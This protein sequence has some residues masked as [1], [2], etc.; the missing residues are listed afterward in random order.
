MLP[1]YGS[2]SSVTEAA[3]WCSRMV[4]STWVAGTFNRLVGR[5]QPANHVGEFRDESR[6]ANSD[7]PRSRGRQ[8]PTSKPAF[9][10][11]AMV[12]V[13]RP[14]Q[15]MH[16]PPLPNR[17]RPANSSCLTVSGGKHACSSGTRSWWCPG[18][19]RPARHVRHGCS[20]RVTQ[21]GN[22]KRRVGLRR[23]AFS[24]FPRLLQA[25]VSACDRAGGWARES[26]ECHGLKR[27]RG[28]PTPRRR[29][30]HA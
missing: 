11:S 25:S 3:S 21:G 23:G 27:G 6:P 20:W 30:H 19:R 1:G 17:W 26:F 29:T 22:R 7:T 8:S 4:T 16:R 13:L 9:R 18:S 14:C 2:G 5:L 28:L 15:G 12:V 24:L 10:A